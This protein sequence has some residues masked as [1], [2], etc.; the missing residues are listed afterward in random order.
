[1]NRWAACAIQAAVREW[2]VQRRYQDVM[3]IQTQTKAQAGPDILSHVHTNEQGKQEC[4]PV[5][6]VPSAAVAVPR[7]G[8]CPGAVSA[9][10]PPPWTE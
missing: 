8:V 6:C 5:G 4:I 3:T 1:M 7:E 9:C 10:P 2:I